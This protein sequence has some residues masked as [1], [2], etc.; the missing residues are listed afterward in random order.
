MLLERINLVQCQPPLSD[1]HLDKRLTIG[2]GGRQVRHQQ[3]RAPRR[4]TVYLC[5]LFEG[6]AD[7]F[8]LL[9]EFSIFQTA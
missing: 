7:T 9:D 4:F 8:A 3:R 5:G 2:A 6:V 1:L